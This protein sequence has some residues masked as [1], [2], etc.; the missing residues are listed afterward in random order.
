MVTRR[1]KAGSSKET[2]ISSESFRGR[3][4]ASDAAVQDMGWPETG[5]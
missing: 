4:R 2:E 3:S 1:R 5:D